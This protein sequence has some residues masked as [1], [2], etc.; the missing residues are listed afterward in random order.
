M[1]VDA[2]ICGTAGIDDQLVLVRG[3]GGD[4]GGVGQ[5]ALL[6]GQGEV[7][8]CIDVTHHVDLVSPAGLRGGIININ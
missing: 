2:G 6:H 4:Q 7:G 3:V 1:H 8:H 5:P